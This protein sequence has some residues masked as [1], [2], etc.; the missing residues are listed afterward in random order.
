VIGL[1]DQHET[2]ADV[3]ALVDCVTGG[4]A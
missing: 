4:T 2:C 1:V 3:A